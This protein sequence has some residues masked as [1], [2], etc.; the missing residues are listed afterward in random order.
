MSANELK[1]HRLANERAVVSLTG[2]HDSYSAERIT[3]G[4]R[5]LLD[6]GYDVEIDLRQATFVD[7]VTVAALIEAHRYAREKGSSLSVVIG[8]STGWA[9]DDREAAALLSRVPMR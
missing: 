8:E 6:E 4:V 5:A 1:F 7:S 2:D 3:S 9:D